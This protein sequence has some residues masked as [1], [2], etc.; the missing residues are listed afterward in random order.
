[1]A[2]SVG[3]GSAIWTGNLVGLTPVGATVVGD[4]RVS[5]DLGTLTGAADFTALETWD[6]GVAPGAA[7][8][9]ARWGD[10]DLS[11]GIAIRGG[12]TEPGVAGHTAYTFRETGGD[13]GTLTGT[14]VGQ[15]HEG[16]AGTLVRDDVT[17]AFGGAR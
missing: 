17:A 1:M 14:F 16:V 12:E 10:G 13:A 5:V 3:E 2:E 11:Y 9:G 7:G 4:A 6:A 15:Q 8:T